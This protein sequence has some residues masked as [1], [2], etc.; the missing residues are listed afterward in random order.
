MNIHIS[1][2]LS[3]T[4]NAAR[5]ATQQFFTPKHAEFE[6]MQSYTTAADRHINES[7]RPIF[8]WL[9]LESSKAAL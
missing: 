2:K 7:S 8:N 5:V 1:E 3:T 6:S 4:I 9:N